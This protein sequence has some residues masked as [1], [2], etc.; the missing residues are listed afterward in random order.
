MPGAVV[1]SELLEA[2]ERAAVCVKPERSGFIR[3]AEDKAGPIRQ[4]TQQPLCRRLEQLWGELLF[5]YK[6]KCQEFGL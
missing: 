4:S 6:R 2:K 5:K 1:F 3:G